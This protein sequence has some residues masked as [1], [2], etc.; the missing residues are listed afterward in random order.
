MHYKLSCG[1]GYEKGYGKCYG[2]GYGGSVFGEDCLSII[3]N[4]CCG[5]SGECCHLSTESVYWAVTI[6][7]AYI[8][9]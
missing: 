8:G 5:Y 3:C 6:F 1:R 7:S 9:L 4:V 2:F